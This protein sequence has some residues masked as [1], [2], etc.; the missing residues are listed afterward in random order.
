MKIHKEMVQGSDEWLQ[1][2]CGLLTASEMKLI[3]T[4]TLKLASNEKERQHLYELLAQR[5]NQYVEPHYISDDMLRGHEDELRAIQL[6]SEE[7]A[8]VETVGFIT[9]DKWGFVLGY[10][11]DAL[12]GDDGLIE[13]KSRRQKYQAQTIVECVTS[14]K[15]MDEYVLQAQAGLLISGRKWLDHISYCGGMPMVPI[16]VYPDPTIQTAILEAAQNFETRLSEKMEIY[17]TNA[18]RFHMTERV[19]EEEMVI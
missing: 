3:L 5:I 13:V 10:S 8:P 17:K 18:T 9:E 11:P 7:Y 16:R 15:I 14:G 2:R 12:V 6:Y 1:A 4:P 19:I